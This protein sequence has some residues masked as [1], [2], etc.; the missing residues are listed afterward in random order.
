M[1]IITPLLCAAQSEWGELKGVVT[2]KTDYGSPAD[3]GAEVIVYFID[4]VKF[5]TGKYHKER[6]EDS[7]I[8][9][10]LLATIYYA[11]WEHTPIGRV[12]REM[13]RKLKSLNAYPEEKLRELDD[14][15]AIIIRERENRQCAKTTV[16][17][18]GNYSVKLHSGYYGIIFRSTHLNSNSKT[19][20]NG[21][22]MLDNALIKQGGIT[23]KSEEM[24]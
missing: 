13:V 23:D 10:S 1:V 17:E 3:T 8:N 20:T 6:I 22:I 2:Y 24:L 7:L 12:Q 16:D 21:D 11:E 9:N 15:A 4:S 5:S 14:L 18:K 19:E